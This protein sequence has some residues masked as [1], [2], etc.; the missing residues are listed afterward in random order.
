MNM[1]GICLLKPERPHEEGFASHIL[2]IGEMLFL[3][4][5]SP[6]PSVSWPFGRRYC[7]IVVSA[8]LF[9]PPHWGR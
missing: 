4:S 6:L 5:F 9:N 2:T 1:L 3:R 7:G 8:H